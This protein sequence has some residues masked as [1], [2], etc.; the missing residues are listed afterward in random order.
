MDLN[1]FSLI[2][3]IT[4]FCDVR[5]N[6]IYKSVPLLI[7]V[8]SRLIR[9]FFIYSAQTKN[10]HIKKQLKRESKNNSESIVIM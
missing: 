2:E 10:P 3:T 9:F 7:H 4:L 1:L 8:F 5:A 6:P